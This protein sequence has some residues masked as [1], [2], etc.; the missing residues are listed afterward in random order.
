MLL[1]RGWSRWRTLEARALLS[2][3]APP[4]YH[5]S[6]VLVVVSGADLARDMVR[7]PAHSR[8]RFGG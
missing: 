8:Q 3:A 4:T 7:G 5:A 2:A 1:L 6:I